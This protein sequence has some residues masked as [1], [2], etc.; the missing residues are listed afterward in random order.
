[1]TPLPNFATSCEIR[2][3][4]PRRFHGHRD[5]ITARALNGPGP[6]RV[7][8]RPPPLPPGVGVDPRGED[9]FP[10]VKYGAASQT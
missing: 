9:G 6:S 7:P 2:I 5:A 4:S 8:S 3:V 1:M 10:P